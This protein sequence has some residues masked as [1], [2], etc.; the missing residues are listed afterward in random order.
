[1]D[2]TKISTSNKLTDKIYGSLS[3]ILF[4]LAWEIGP[5]VGLLKSTL[6]SPPSEVLLYYITLINDDHLFTHISVSLLRSVS[7]FLLAILIGTPLGFLLGGWFKTFEKIVEPVL[8]FLGQFNPFSLF[9][10]FILIL[11]IGEISKITMIFWVCL[12]PIIFNTTTGVRE[13]DPLLIKSGRA[14]GLGRVSLLIKIVFPASLAYIFNGFKLA[15]GTAFFMLI[16]AEMIG[17]SQGLGWLTLNAQVNF[18]IP[19]LYA[20]TVLI[21]A[22]GL[23]ISH[24]FSL[25]EKKTILWKDTPVL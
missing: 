9:P 17:A 24:L 22:L 5:R 19:K 20:G 8:K 13:V 14:M 16:A 4:F 12:W 10:I 1:M 11:G 23:L 25:W 15:S 21:S 2:K 6:V 3:I 18:Q 7:G